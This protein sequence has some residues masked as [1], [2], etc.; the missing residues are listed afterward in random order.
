MLRRGFLGSALCAAVQGQPKAKSVF[1]VALQLERG[2]RILDLAP[3]RDAPPLVL[4]RHPDGGLLFYNREDQW[5]REPLPQPAHS[6]CPSA[7]H[8]WIAADTGIW[9]RPRAGGKW[10][11][12]WEGEGLERILFSGEKGFAVGAGKTVLQAGAEGQWTRVPAADEPTTNTAATTY[13]WIHFVNDRIGIISGASRPQRKG[14]TSDL[15]FWLDPQRAT[16][17]KEWPGASLTLETRDGGRNWHHSVTSIFGR[18][19]RVRYARDGRGLALIEFHDEFE[20]PCEVFAI[21]LKAG[22]SARVFR[23]K[24]RA[25]T[26]TWLY[27]GEGYLAAIEPPADPAETPQGRLCLMHSSGLRDWDEI[28]LPPTHG[29]RA[30]L[31]GAP[32]GELWLAS[33]SGTLLRRRVTPASVKGLR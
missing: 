28:E 13:H 30:L 3:D 1:E 11:K 33:D 24:D 27:P 2:V 31:A 25:V 20:Y 17:R 16:R 6:V 18:I 23:R 19:T 14:Q 15:P 10:Q 9:R 8:F 29:K 22:S 7:E 12:M 4:A 21:D 5:L 26:D 32:S